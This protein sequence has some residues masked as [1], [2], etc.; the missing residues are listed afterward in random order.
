MLTAHEARETALQHHE[1]NE[2]L[3][4]VLASI[5]PASRSGAF[6]DTIMGAITEE[7]VDALLALG[8][9]V[10]HVEGGIVVTWI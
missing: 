2:E 4:A 6:R 5:A 1:R 3:R 8:Y 9:D 10:T 7:T